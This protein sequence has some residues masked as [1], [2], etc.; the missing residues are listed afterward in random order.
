MHC[1]SS[2]SDHLWTYKWSNWTNN[3]TFHQDFIHKYSSKYSICAY[4]SWYMLTISSLVMTLQFQLV[5]Y[6]ELRWLDF[7]ISCFCKFKNSYFS[8]QSGTMI[9]NCSKLRF[10]SCLYYGCS[11]LIYW[12]VSLDTELLISITSSVWNWANANGIN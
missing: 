6:Y 4:F 7:W 8:F 3:G 2:F 9:R 11:H 5:E 12:L 10:Y 1:R